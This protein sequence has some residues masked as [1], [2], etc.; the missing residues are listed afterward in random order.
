MPGPSHSSRFYHPNNIGWGLQIIK[1]LIMYFYPLHCYLVPLKIKYS[2]QDSIFKHPQPTFL[3]QCDLPS[4]TPTV[5]TIHKTE[6]VTILQN[7]AE[8]DLYRSKH[9]VLNQQQFISK[10][11]QDLNTVSLII[12]SS[13]TCFC[14]STRTER[15]KHAENMQIN[16]R[17]VFRCCVWVYI[18]I[19]WLS[20][21]SDV[22]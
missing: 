10:Q 22:T 7:K 3:P 8:D 6:K 14:P 12:C 2:P 4:F 1:L 18:D 13:S 16:E 20:Q 11:T 19:D 5:C 15:Q 17:K 9:T 21:G